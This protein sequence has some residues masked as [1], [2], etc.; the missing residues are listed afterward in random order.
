MGAS[1][2]FQHEVVRDG[3]F[4]GRALPRFSASASVFESC[5]FD[6][7]RL[8]SV[9]FGAGTTMSTYRN[10]SFDNADLDVTPGGFARFESCTF[11][12]TRIRDW[13]CFAVELVDCVFTGRIDTAFFNGTV[14]EEDRRYLSRSVNE[15][16]GND[17]SGADLVDVAFRTGIDLTQQRLPSGPGYVYIPDAVAVSGELRRRVVTLEDLELRKKLMPHVLGLE[18]DVEA[19]QHQ[20]LITSAGLGRDDRVRAVLLR[21]I[22]EASA[23]A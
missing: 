21:M 18:M 12:G 8:K 23:A 13:R 3:D 11:R 22:E 20:V 16:H 4:T 19:G 7:A 15:F 17:F 2:V 1:G 14:P 5:R 10:C 9:S 6:S